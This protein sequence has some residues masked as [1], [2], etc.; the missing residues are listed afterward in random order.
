EKRL[1]EL[2]VKVSQVSTQVDNISVRQ[3]YPGLDQVKVITY[4]GGLWQKGSK[5]P[6]EKW[7]GVYIFPYAYGDF[8]QAEMETLF[9]DLRT[10]GYTPLPGMFGI[11]GPYATGAGDLGDGGGT[12]ASINYFSTSSEPMSAEVRAIVL[13]DLH[14]DSIDT[15][16]VDASKLQQDD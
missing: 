7:V 9:K 13:K 5:K 10:A 4:K 3:E 1:A 12:S 6:D 15:R 16:Y 2:D 11:G 8:S 14:V